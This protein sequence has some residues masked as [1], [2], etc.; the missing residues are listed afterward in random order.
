MVVN[1][2]K[3][4]RVLAVTTE[5]CV[6]IIC[7]RIYVN[8]LSPDVRM[9][10]NIVTITEEHTTRDRA[11]S[12]LSESPSSFGTYT[13]RVRLPADLAE[14]S[15]SKSELASLP[16]IDGSDTISVTLFMATKETAPCPLSTPG[17]R[18][19]SR[20]CEWELCDS[21]CGW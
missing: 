7:R 17:V 1:C 14:I 11:R 6:S 5:T 12:S 9:S 21:D 4:T 19:P 20:V 3:G 8:S 16:A 13:T 10:L 15:N 2:F 18:F